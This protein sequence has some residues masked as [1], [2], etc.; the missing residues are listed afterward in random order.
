MWS[1]SVRGLSGVGSGEG[2][3]VRRS[4]PPECDHRCCSAPRGCVPST[5]LGASVTRIWSNDAWTGLTGSLSRT[6]RSHC[7]HITKASV[8]ARHL[9]LKVRSG[10][11]AHGG[12]RG[13]ITVSP[14]D[15]P[16]FR[17]QRGGR[18][19]SVGPGRGTQ[20]SSPVC[21]AG[22]GTTRLRQPG[23]NGLWRPRS[24]LASWGS[25]ESVRTRTLRVRLRDDACFSH[26]RRP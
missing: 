17:S 14:L 12:G 9:P 8:P 11:G 25:T 18:H 7:Y 23:P 21:G 4:A 19:P 5:T 10:T 2:Q 1:A 20:L 15:R 26:H 13:W 3:P 6:Y 24:R 22:R 16:A